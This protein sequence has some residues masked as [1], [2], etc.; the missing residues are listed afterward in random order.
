MGPRSLLC[1]WRDLSLA[2]DA[3]D[4]LLRGAPIP[5]SLVAPFVKG[6]CGRSVGGGIDPAE[7][8][9]NE[10]GASLILDARYC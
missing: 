5:L 3:R 2:R 8:P 1:W 9:Q 6:S 10:S 7:K 4:S